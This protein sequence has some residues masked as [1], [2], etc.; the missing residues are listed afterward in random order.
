MIVSSILLSF[1]VANYEV[2]PC[3]TEILGIIYIFFTGEPDLNQDP[4]SLAVAVVQVVLALRFTR[5]KLRL[6]FLV[7]FH[8]HVWE[9]VKT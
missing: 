7:L 4:V 8:R 3:L 6:V 9:A 1:S 2:S 5:K